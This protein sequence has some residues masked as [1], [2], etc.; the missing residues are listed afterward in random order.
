MAPPSDEAA[1]KL[2][3][4]DSIMLLQPGRETIIFQSALANYTQERWCRLKV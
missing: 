4:K 3:W 2:R 1:V